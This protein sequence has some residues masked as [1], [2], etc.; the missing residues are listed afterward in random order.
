MSRR[1]YGFLLLAIIFLLAMPLSALADVGAK[2]NGLQEDVA[3]SVDNALIRINMSNGGVAVVGTTG[4]DPTYVGDENKRLLYGYG[5]TSII[6]TGYPT[7]RIQRGGQTTDYVLRDVDLSAAAH[8]EG[9]AVVAGW[10]ID[11]VQVVQRV[12]LSANPFSGREDMAMFTF[13]LSNQGAEAQVG[14]RLMLDLQVG[15]NDHAPLLV[16]EAGGLTTE[17]DFGSGLVFFRAFES[18]TYAPDSLRALG[19]L[20]GH[21]LTAPDRVVLATWSAPFGDGNGIHEFPWDYAVTP[22]AR[23]GDSAMGYWWNPVTLS[24]GQSITYKTQYGLGTGGGSS[25]FDAPAAV[26]CNDGT[27]DATL[28]VSN[29]S[30]YALTNGQATISLPA[31]LSL[32]SGSAAVAFGDVPAEG[33]ASYTWHV[34]ADTSA[35]ANLAYSAVAT[36]D[37]LTSPLTAQASIQVPDCSAEPTPGPTSEPTPGPTP[38]PTPEVPEPGSLTLLLVGLGGLTAAWKRRSRSH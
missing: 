22:G 13:E 24:Q 37:D 4:G 27:F 20:S 30:I 16:P 12:S 18:A 38:N 19:I 14:L 29:P 2:S 1:R 9:S 23:V 31:G 25:W 26:T 6:E 28:W 15:S 7:L 34:V 35:P 21:G 3:A 10:D 33:A 32:A 8:V 5:A 11:G 17:T 36:F